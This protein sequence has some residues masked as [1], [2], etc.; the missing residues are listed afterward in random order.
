WAPERR[1]GTPAQ[2]LDGRQTEHEC[3]CSGAHPCRAKTGEERDDLE[4]FAVD[5]R[6]KAKPD[7]NPQD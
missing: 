5:D 2:A 7:H 1:Q 4:M 3:R 6:H